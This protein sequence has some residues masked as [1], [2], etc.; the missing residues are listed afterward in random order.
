MQQ[1]TLTIDEVAEMLHRRPETLRRRW[2]A[3]NREHDFPRPLPG[4][5]LVWSRALVVAWIEAGGA[6]AAPSAEGSFTQRARESLE[7]QFVE[8]L[9]GQTP[10]Q[11]FH[12]KRRVA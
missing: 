7:R 6:L 8:P 2:R 5:G 4:L 1:V 3:L 12:S 9:H 11:S 10:R